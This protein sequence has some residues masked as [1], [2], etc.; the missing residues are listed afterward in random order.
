VTFLENST[1]YL[2]NTDF[3]EILV[4]NWKKNTSLNFHEANITVTEK[5]EKDISKKEN[6]QLCSQYPSWT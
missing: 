2:R 1:K 6:Y 4:E 3:T 5:P